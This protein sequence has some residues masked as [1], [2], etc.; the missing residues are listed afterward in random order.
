LLSYTFAPRERG[1]FS[2]HEIRAD[3]RAYGAPSKPSPKIQSF[4]TGDI[5]LL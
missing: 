1:A 5:S 3:G 4:V 2:D